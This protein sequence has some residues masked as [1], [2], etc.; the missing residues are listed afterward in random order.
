MSFDM[1]KANNKEYVIEKVKENYGEENK[2]V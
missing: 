2:N 1:S